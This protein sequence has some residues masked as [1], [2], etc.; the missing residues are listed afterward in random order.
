MVR[1]KRFEMDGV[2]LKIASMSV[3]EAEA[4]VDEGR[5]FIERMKT[6]EVKPEEWLARRDRAVIASLVKAGGE[7]DE[8][9]IKHEFDLPLLDA[10]YSAILEFSGLKPGEAVA[11]SASPKS[12]AA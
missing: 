7:W 11:V 5:V 6:A 10:V 4:F 12:E 1:T 3:A 2:S 9:K 8:D